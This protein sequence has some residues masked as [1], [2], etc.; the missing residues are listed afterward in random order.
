MKNQYR[1]LFQLSGRETLLI[2][3]DDTEEYSVRLETL[4]QWILDDLKLNLNITKVDN[5]SD[6]NKPVSEAQ[7]LLLNSKLKNI[8]DRFNVTFH[9]IDQRLHVLEHEQ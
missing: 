1:E 4:K 9:N 3:R 5:T 8:E 6:A 2:V 7:A